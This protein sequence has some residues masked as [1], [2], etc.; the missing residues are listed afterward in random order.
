MHDRWGLWTS[1]CACNSSRGQKKSRR[2]P[3]GVGDASRSC[4]SEVPAAQRPSQAMQPLV[5][6]GTSPG[7]L[8]PDAAVGAHAPC[9]RTPLP[10]TILYAS[11]R[12]A[13]ASCWPAQ[14]VRLPCG[15]SWRSSGRVYCQPA[16][17]TSLL[18]TEGATGLGVGCLGRRNIMHALLDNPG[19]GT[20][21][22][23]AVMWAAAVCMQTAKQAV[24]R[25]LSRCLLVPSNPY[26]SCQC[27]S[28]M[29][30]EGKRPHQSI[31]TERQAGH[32]AM[33]TASDTR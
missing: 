16:C 4:S 1:A 29:K 20:T 32:M 22:A 27:R 2:V 5:L 12:W 3:A 14:S 26:R 9:E 6:A 23:K 33:A 19:D 24:A 8:L 15:P 10:H 11:Q 31:S 17:G 18:H 7:A 25:P 30:Q 21:E 28:H 13:T